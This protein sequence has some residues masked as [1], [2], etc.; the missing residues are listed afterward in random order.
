MLEPRSKLD[1]FQKYVIP[2]Q[3]EPPKTGLILCYGDSTF[4]RWTKAFDRTP[5]E[6]VIRKK[7]GSQAIVNHGIGGGFSDQFL[8]YYPIAV[9]PWKPSALV[10]HS[11][12]NDLA[13]GYTPEEIMFLQS[14]VLEYAREDFPGIRLFLCNVRPLAKQMYRECSLWLSH[15]E[16]LN[17]LMDDYVRSHPDT[18]LVDHRKFAPIFEEGF[19]GDYSK[20][21]P[22]YFIEDQVHLTQEGYD[23]YR[24]FL[25][26]YLEDL[27]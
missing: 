2:F 8:Y 12:A 6:E 22:E 1:V 13:K 9:R 27:L 7:D 10:F 18:T 17:S 3:A 26:P 4:T 16:E 14:R 24:E 15:V 5:L 20:T 25:L 23:L 21:R 19:A 11:S